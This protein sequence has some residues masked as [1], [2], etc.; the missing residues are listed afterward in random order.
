MKNTENIDDDKQAGEHK[1]YWVTNLIRI[2]QSKEFR[3][4]SRS[5]CQYTDWKVV[6]KNNN[7]DNYSYLSTKKYY[8]VV[9]M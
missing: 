5:K 7:A 8:V 1:G 9:K 3:F 6:N 4:K 2:W